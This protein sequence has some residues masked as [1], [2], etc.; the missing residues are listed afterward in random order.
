MSDENKKSLFQLTKEY[1][2]LINLIEYSEG[3]LS[4]EIE[5]ALLLNKE[6]IEQKSQGYFF[7]LKELEY[8]KKKMQEFQDEAK[9]CVDFYESQ[10]EKLKNNMSKALQE[11]NMN[12]IGNFKLVRTKPVVKI[13]G[14]N[15]IPREYIKEKLVLS[16]DKLK[17]A[18]DLQQGKDVD[19]AVLVENT[20][21]KIKLNS[22]KEIK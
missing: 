12:E 2:S 21:L 5:S 17:I 8:K 11:L 9:K 19:G 15:F 6:N 16:V 1:Q 7:W 13:L 22:L 20:Y 14:E 3:E 4:P 10:I 18:E